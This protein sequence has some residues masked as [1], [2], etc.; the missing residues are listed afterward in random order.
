MKRIA[1]LVLA[2]LGLLT[3]PVWAESGIREKTVQF[4]KGKDGVLLK[5]HLK[6]DETVDYKLGAHAGQTM[7][8]T[9]KSSNRM[10][11][12]NVL[13]PGTD[14]ALFVG[15]DS[16]SQFSGALPKSGTYTVRVYLMRAAA[17]R[18]ETA[19]YSLD[20]RITGK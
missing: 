4:P 13:P 11:Y 15:A 9:L 5:D 8:V 12:F 1:P 10:N 17:R 16:G 2:G 18:N 3:T 14:T 20:L 7:N 19:D 6:G